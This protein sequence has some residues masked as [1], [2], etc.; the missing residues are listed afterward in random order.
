MKSEV[1]G[2]SS[3]FV[4]ANCTIVQLQ[5]I[6]ST[7]YTPGH[8]AIDITYI[9]GGVTLSCS[10]VRKL[11]ARGEGW[12]VILDPDSESE[13]SSIAPSS[14]YVRQGRGAG[15][16]RQE[17][18]AGSTAK[19]GNSQLVE[20][21]RG[22]ILRARGHISRRPSC[23]AHSY[24][25]C[26]S[27]KVET[28][29]I[30]RGHIFKGHTPPSKLRTSLD[31]PR[32]LDDRTIAPWLYCSIRHYTISRLEIMPLLYCTIRLLHYCWTIA[33]FIHCTGTCPPSAAPVMRA[34]DAR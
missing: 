25:Y 30:F 14:N 23:L 5:S 2:F 16:A 33:L 18:S 4:D 31:T 26:K 10:P 11:I 12:P 32:R 29:H 3:S 15:S 6:V 20:A 21:Q 28:P 9:S 19:L 27:A 22:L 34:N 8:W 24:P 7:T 1:G 13:P 17:W